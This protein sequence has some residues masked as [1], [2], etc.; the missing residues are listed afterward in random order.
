MPFL[1][2]FYLSI[3]SLIIELEEYVTGIGIVLAIDAGHKMIACLYFEGRI[4]AID[5][6]VLGIS[7]YS[8]QTGLVWPVP[9]FH[10][11]VGQF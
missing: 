1:Q 3:T 6:S 2:G 10:T 8:Q 5:V 11:R 4:L 9:V 7:G